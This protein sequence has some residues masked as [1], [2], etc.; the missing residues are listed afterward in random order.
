M[1]KSQTAKTEQITF[2][3][4]CELEP[5][6]ELLYRIAKMIGRRRGQMFCANTIWYTFFKPVVVELIGDHRAGEL[7]RRKNAEP[8]ILKK[9]DFSSFDPEAVSSERPIRISSSEDDRLNSPYA[10]DLAY[11][12]IYDA[13]PDCNHAGPICG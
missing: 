8:F 2:E 12:T 3:E 10:Y 1:E 5:E 11:Q 7:K 13:L 4:I 9:F 6:I